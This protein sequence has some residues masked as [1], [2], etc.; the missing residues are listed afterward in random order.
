VEG[1]APV[2]PGEHK[3]YVFKQVLGFSD[4]EMSEL[5]GGNIIFSGRS[6]KGRIERRT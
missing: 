2:I 4:E 5:K 1:N 6:E 3:D